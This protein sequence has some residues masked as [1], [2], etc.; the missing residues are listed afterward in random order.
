MRRPP[1]Q[2]QLELIPRS[3]NP[4]VVIDPNHR[5]VRL[6]EALDWL[7][8][9]AK[10]E[11]IRRQKLKS[12]AG[13][14]PNL[15][16][17][18]GAV[19]FM[20]V[21]RVTYRE[22]EDQIRHY[23]PARY[24]CGLTESQWTPDFT[25]IH[26]FVTQMGPE[27]LSELNALAVKMAVDAGFGDPGML[28]ADTTAQEGSVSYPTEV[29][30]LASFFRSATRLAKGS[31]QALKAAF[32]GVEGRVERAVKHLRAY[33]L[34]AKNRDERIALTTKA[35]SIAKTVRSKLETALNQTARGRVTKTRK[36]AR[37]R[38]RSLLSVMQQ[39]APQIEYWLETGRVAKGK[40]VSLTMPLLRSIPRGKVGKDVEFGIKWGLQR[41]GGGFVLGQA[42][43]SRGNF[44]DQKHVREALAWHV[45]LFEQPPTAFAYDRGGFCPR[46]NGHLQELGVRHNGI[47]P[48]GKQKWLVDGAQKEKLVKE[49][50][51]IEGDIGSIKSQ[52]YGFNRPAARSERMMI[53]CG[54]RAMLGYNLNKFLRLQARAHG[55]ELIG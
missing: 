34:F 52:R 33:R 39:L 9:E 37:H 27:G 13:R 18:L 38:L 1:G 20:S 3:K 41:I 42:D 17:N 2:K 4:L 10:G 14:P 25:T 55:V 45:E 7:E 53:T 36:S 44:S 29:G 35:L 30:L 32:K 8:L 6:T 43:A 54:H 31:G 47:A 46:N 12:R 26:D 24:L 51:R 28:V 11:E 50:A 21:N 49:R 22:A 23:A 16:A 5:L 19:I 15:R 48:H 40:I